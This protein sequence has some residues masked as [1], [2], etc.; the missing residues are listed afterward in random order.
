LD[1]L[2]E[3]A[4]ARMDHR[5]KLGLFT[6]P[7]LVL[8]ARRDSLIPCSNGERMFA[9]AAAPAS[10]KHMRLF[11]QGDH[12]TVFRANQDEYLAALGEF[13]GANAR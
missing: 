3:A 7:L 9:W 1:E 8:H 10:R 5:R 6:G 12:N 4:Q 13:F 2:R 11:P